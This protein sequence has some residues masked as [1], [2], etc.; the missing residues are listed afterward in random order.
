MWPKILTSFKKIAKMRASLE[1]TVTTYHEW[2]QVQEELKGAQEIYK[3]AAN[4]SEMY[5]MAAMEVDE[6]E[7]REQRL[8][9]RL[10]VLLLPRDPNDD[11]NIMLEIRAGTGGD[12]AGIWAGDLMRLYSRYARDAGLEGELAE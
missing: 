7:D 1:E 2:Q 9:D 10:K 4:D 3:E 12:E 11:K 8:E 5:E 6:L